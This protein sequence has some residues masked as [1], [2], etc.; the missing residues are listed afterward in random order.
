MCVQALV[1]LL[2]AAGPGELHVEH[3]GLQAEGKSELK[4]LAEGFSSSLL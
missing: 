1:Q 4:S 3:P 2:P